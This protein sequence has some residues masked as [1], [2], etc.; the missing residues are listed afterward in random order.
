MR[1]AVIYDKVEEEYLT[2]AKGKS[3]WGS[4]GAAKNAAL[5]EHNNNERWD[6]PNHYHSFADQ[7]RYE[8]RVYDLTTIEYKAV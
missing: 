5:N 3:V 7:D 2:T 6:S 8:C 1:V 4:A